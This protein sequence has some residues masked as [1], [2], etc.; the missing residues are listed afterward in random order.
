MASGFISI[1]DE[2]SFGCRWSGYDLILEIICRELRQQKPFDE[3]NDLAEW[4]ELHFPQKEFKDKDAGWA[5]FH[6]EK[7]R[8]VIR[9]INLYE[10]NKSQLQQFW[11][12]A[13]KGYNKLIAIGDS[14]S[15]LNPEFL[16]ALLKFR[17]EAEKKK[18]F[19]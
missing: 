5:F 11:F 18:F 12:A 6:K 15:N 13:Q 19:T 2:N 17:K 10:L 3:N 8:L 1:D 14:Y 16:L 7:N 4:V 9:S